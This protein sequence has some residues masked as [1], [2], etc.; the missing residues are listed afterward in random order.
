M[1]SSTQG[2]SS[3]SP[4]TA[5]DLR[6]PVLEGL[7]SWLGRFDDPVVRH[8]IAVRAGGPTGL[9]DIGADP[10]VLRNEAATSPLVTRS[11]ASQRLDGS[12]GDSD[13]PERRILTTFWMAKVF[14]DLGL[15]WLPQWSQAVEFLAGIA[16]PD[17]VFSVDGSRTGILSCYVGM[18]ASVYLEGGRR[19]LAEPQ[20]RWIERHQDVRRH[21]Q[22]LRLLPAEPFCDCLTVSHG[23]CM[24]DTTCGL[25]LIKT[26]MALRAWVTDNPRDL[27]S[28]ELLGTIR[29][30][31]L[32]RE[33]IHTGDGSVLPLGERAS[34]ASDWLE[35]TFPLDWRTDLIEVVDFVNHTGPPDR[36]MQA[37]LDQLVARQLE[38]NTW[39][40]RRVFRPIHLPAL[41]R[42]SRRCGSPYVTLRAI[43]AVT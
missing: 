16:H 4:G 24:S 27:G 28:A 18:A 31:F 17:D 6:F 12:W 34:H 25:G 11:L 35:P 3:S 9:G 43:L 20:I 33:L 15:T 2:T 30:S 5:S 32:E 23:G 21:G 14:A 26:G 42:R 13:H 19:D 39:P 41:E 29:E 1:V 22:S 38:D 37:A 40:L 10:T 36:R 8:L 7:W